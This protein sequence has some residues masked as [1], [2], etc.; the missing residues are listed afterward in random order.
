MKRTTATTTLGPSTRKM[1][2]RPMKA[3]SWWSD[4]AGRS[5]SH[6][7]PPLSASAL[8]TRPSQNSH[9]RRSSIGQI[10]PTSLRHNSPTPLVY[11]NRVVGC[12]HRLR[13]R[14]WSRRIHHEISC[15]RRTTK[16][17]RNTSSPLA[18]MAR[19]GPVHRLPRILTHYDAVGRRHHW[20]VEAFAEH[21]RACSCHSKA[22]KKSLC[23][24]L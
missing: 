15:S 16:K 10:H 2:L 14:R 3:S 9:Q 24:P 5:L 1:I 7:R 19:I 23:H 18:L 22:T 17:A 8:T 4:L 12:L 21:R 6:A 11:G 20:K 13:P